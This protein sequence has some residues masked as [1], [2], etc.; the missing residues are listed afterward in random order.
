MLFNNTKWNIE[1]FIFPTKNEDVPSRDQLELELALA[2]TG[3]GIPRDITNWA[4]M[5]GT[6]KSSIPSGSSRVSQGPK[7]K[8]RKC[9]LDCKT[10]LGTVTGGLK[11]T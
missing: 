8:I 11:V 6:W 7:L 2:R 3:V 5:S 9:E 1:A 4:S 10:G